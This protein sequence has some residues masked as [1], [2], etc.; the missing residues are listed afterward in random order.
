MINYYKFIFDI[1]IIIIFF[2]LY[3]DN[4]NI[5]VNYFKHKK[6]YIR[7]F[8]YKSFHNIKNIVKNNL[9]CIY[10]SN[11]DNKENDDINT[12][13]SDTSSEISSNINTSCEK[14]TFD[15]D[16]NNFN[17]K[18]NKIDSHI[19]NSNQNYSNEINAD[20]AILNKL[21]NDTIYS[22]NINTQALTTPNIYS[23]NINSSKAIIEDIY[24]NHIY[25]KNVNSDNLEINNGIIKNLKNEIFES[26]EGI[27]EDLKTK[28]L[29]S[30]KAHMEILETNK[31]NTNSLDAILM[32]SKELISQNIKS[33]DICSSTG[34][35]KKIIADDI[36][37]K[38]MTIVSDRRKKN[39]IIYNPVNSD[40]L[41]NINMVSF[42]YNDNN[43]HHIGFIAQDIE[44]YYPELIKKDTKGYLSVK[45]LEMIPILLDY[46]QKMK[47]SISQLEEKMKDKI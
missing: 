4:G 6:K 18:V 47:K 44:K 10:L 15:L 7:P 34:T 13:D 46:N 40:A 12:T 24:N 32:N 42:K 26:K 5:F 25:S 3:N 8:L 29:S 43:Q 11:D 33:Q 41:D 39:S 2:R 21:Y 28:F 37:C 1:I 20:K 17:I 35:Y 22:K 19:S 31:L 16:L 38:D 9:Y 23:E 30:D 27:V 36:E 14:D 45:Y